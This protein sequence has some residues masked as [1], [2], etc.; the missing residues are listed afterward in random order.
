LIRSSPVKLLVRL[1]DVLPANKKELPANARRFPATRAPNSLFAQTGNW[2]VICCF[3]G[4]FDGS[5]WPNSLKN[6]KN[7]LQFPCKWQKSQ[8]S[9]VRC[10]LQAPPS[11]LAI[12]VYFAVVA[13]RNLLHCLSE[14]FAPN[15]ALELVTIAAGHRFVSKSAV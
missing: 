2:D 13:G 9:R 4:S 14:P 11:S 8:Q 10:R 7:S 6:A 5:N 3:Y 15:W 1:V 12:F